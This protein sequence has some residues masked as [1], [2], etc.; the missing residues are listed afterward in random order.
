MVLFAAP[1]FADTAPLKLDDAV[2]RSH[3]EHKP[4]LVEFYT[5]WCQPCKEFD[6]SVL[7]DPRVQ[8]ALRD[9]VWVRYDAEAEPGLSAAAKLKVATY[10]TFLVLDGDG[11]ERGRDSGIG[12][13]DSGITRFLGLI[14]SASFA[15]L[16]EAG[17]TLRLKEHPDDAATRLGAARWYEKRGQVTQ[18]LAHYDAVAASGKVTPLQAGEAAAIAARLRRV[19]RWRQQL[20]AEKRDLVTAHPEAASERDLAIAMIGAGA[21]TAPSRQLAG[22]VLAAPH[23]PEVLNSLIYVALAAGAVDEALAAA[24]RLAADK[25]PSHMDTLA[26]CHH[27]HGDRTSALRIEDEAI[28][29]VKGSPAEPALAANR[30]RFASG[31]AES[32]AV[33]A[34]RESISAIWTTMA[35]IEQSQAGTSDA[36]MGPALIFYSAMRKLVERAAATCTGS[37]GETESAFARLELGADGH[38]KAAVVLVEP[39]APA[40]L[41][42]CLTKALVGQSLPPAP[43]GARPSAEIPLKPSH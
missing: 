37:I 41:R 32:P 12:V 11:I 1:T 28:S 5:D 2:Q 29:K 24:T 7:P 6:G 39:D 30:K 3:R 26:E 31:H 17:V 42:G 10:P 16:D 18:A 35:K 27:M 15:T 38:V 22:R 36:A 14:S 25:D 43:L 9:V 33:V 20:V 13:G 34:S 23:E 4:L 40:E 19:E 21:P 8:A